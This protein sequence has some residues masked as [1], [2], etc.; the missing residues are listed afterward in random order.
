L[1][2]SCGLGPESGYD[3]SMFLSF[4]KHVQRLIVECAWHLV[5]LPVVTQYHPIWLHDPNA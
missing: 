5:Y 1:Q 3:P 4:Q 2:H